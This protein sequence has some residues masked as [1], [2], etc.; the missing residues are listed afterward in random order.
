MR[1]P[2]ARRLALFAVLALGV[3][4]SGRAADET[5]CP[6]PAAPPAEPLW[7]GSVGLS[8]LATSG[9]TDTSSLGLAGAWSRKP[10]PWGV[11]IAAAA[12]RAESEGT[13][14]AERYFAGVRGKRA[15]DARFDA[16]AGLSD[17]RNVFAG[18]DSRIVAEAGGVWHLLR[19]AP[20]GAPATAESR[21][22]LAVDAGLTWTR[23]D[24]IG[25]RRDASFGALAGVTYAWQITPNATF[26]ERF[27]VYP[28]FE[29]SDDW[30]LRSETSFDAAFA[31]SWALRA[32]YAYVR[33]NRP[34]PGFEKTDTAT[35]LS[36][37]WKM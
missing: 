4:T 27:V 3:S 2:T 17:E 19:G 29:R 9:N 22:D 5:L 24:P 7:T 12:T 14:T 6:C 30:R 25:G 35:S 18:F 36:L 21:H 26:R 32:G 34:V 28:S 23:E 33:D 13:R 1:N 10:T 11:D 16:F 31:A 8:Y 20:A 37:V 15:L